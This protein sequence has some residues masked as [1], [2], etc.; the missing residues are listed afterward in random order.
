MALRGFILFLFGRFA[1]PPR[2]V[3]LVIPHISAAKPPL[4]FRFLATWAAAT[5]WPK[6]LNALASV[7]RS[8]TFVVLVKP[9]SLVA[10]LE[11]CS[12]TLPGSVLAIAFDQPWPPPAEALFPCVPEAPIDP[13][14]PDP[15]R[16]PCLR[17]LP[18]P[19]ITSTQS[20]ANANTTLPTNL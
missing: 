15:P 10:R 5:N 16:W 3:F 2:G 9:S 6:F 4:I 18:P 20:A 14:A 17:P 11:L 1:L 19:R 7:L 8:V 13:S 12:K